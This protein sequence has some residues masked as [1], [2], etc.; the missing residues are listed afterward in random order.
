MPDADI[1]VERGWGY[2]ITNRPVGRPASKDAGIMGREAQGAEAQKPNSVFESA[3]PRTIAGSGLSADAA[4]PSDRPGAA[5]G[6]L[7]MPDV[8]HSKGG[9]HA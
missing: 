8:N 4:E 9:P 6:R 1:G 5:L 7:Q 2:L 3:G